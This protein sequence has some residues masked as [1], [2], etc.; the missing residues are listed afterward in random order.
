MTV[1]RFLDRQ[2]E[3]DLHRLR[4]GVKRLKRGKWTQD[5]I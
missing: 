3:D 5:V 4:R 1:A 2:I